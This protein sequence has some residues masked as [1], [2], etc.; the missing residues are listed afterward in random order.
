MMRLLVCFSGVSITFYF[1]FFK[2]QSHSPISLSVRGDGAAH[3]PENVV[4][5]HE[6]E[7]CTFPLAAQLSH[8]PVF[9]WDQR[10]GVK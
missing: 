4:H 5:F 7:V 2:L 1:L 6:A 10:L 8:P 9:M 3:I